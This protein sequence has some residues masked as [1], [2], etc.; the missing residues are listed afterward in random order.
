MPKRPITSYFTAAPSKKPKLS[1]HS[2]LPPSTHPSYPFPI[3]C[4][5]PSLELSSTKPVEKDNNEKDTNEKDTNEKDTSGENANEKDINEKIPPTAITHK[6]DLSILHYHPFLHTSLSKELFLFLRK[7]LPFYRVEYRIARAGVE[8]NVKTPRYT[9]LFGVDAISYF[10]PH[11]GELLDTKSKHP[12]PPDR[13]RCSPR[14]VPQCVEMLRQYVAKRTGCSYN[15]VLIN[16][17]A[18][19]NDSISYHSDDERFLGENPAIASL[20][21]GSR[22]DFLMKHKTVPALTHTF[23]LPSG[24]LLLMRSTTQS[25]WLHSIPKRSS[26]SSTAGDSTA[27]WAGGGRI[28]ITFRN[29]LERGGTENYYCYNIGSGPVY[30]WD[31]VSGKMVLKA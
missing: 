7:Q 27:S 12:V 17:Y 24:D 30:R 3:A 21:L 23:P 25:K 6:Q 29:A 5:P 1:L 13:Y 26:S 22:R 8:T 20:S 10:H 14:P 2:D 28:N 9:S 16:Y 11:S 4:L 31:D 18:D 15:F 19:G